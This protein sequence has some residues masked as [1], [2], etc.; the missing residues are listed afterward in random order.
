MNNIKTIFAFLIVIC[1][2]SVAQ[3][4]RAQT[5]EE[6]YSNI[7]SQIKTNGIR[8]RFVI[9]G[10]EPIGNKSG[11][12]KI[13]KKN[14]QGYEFSGDIALSTSI[15][16]SKNGPRAGDTICKLPFSDGTVY[17][18]VGEVNFS[19]FLEGT[20]LVGEEGETKYKIINAL[21][22]YKFIGE[23]SENTSPLTFAVIKNIGFVYLTGKGKVILPDDEILSFK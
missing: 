16:F 13:M 19:D 3:I 23:G 2:F 4:A 8:E 6:T 12:M 21:K 11:T 20:H 15:I 22:G 10:I 9:R 1:V 18:F 7:I 17:K 14:G 5:V